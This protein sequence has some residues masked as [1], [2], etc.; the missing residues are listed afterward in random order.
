[1]TF[2]EALFENP[3]L[4]NACVAALLASIASGIVGSY[5]VVKRIAFISGGISHSVLGGIGLFLFLERVFLFS[6]ATPLA[7]AFVS[8]IISAIIIGLI[9]I[10]RK[11]RED[12]VIAALWSIGMALG[13]IF[14][15]MTPGFNVELNNFLVG[16]ILWVTDSDL[17]ILALLDA[18]ILITVFFLHQRFL[19]VCFDEDQA[20]LQEQNVPILYLTL[21]VLTGITVVLLIEVVGIILVMTMLTIPAAIAGSF[22]KRLSHMM[23]LATLFSALFS[24]A[25]IL[26]A[27]EWDFPVGATIALVAGLSYVLSLIFSKRPLMKKA[28]I[29]PA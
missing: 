29:K 27:F 7:G 15:A 5:V 17:Y 9:H 8:A 20:Y 21:L 2:L 24:A 28:G 14:I 18:V 10:Y 25:G 11:E 16:N 26:I 4:F 12:S 1:M 3:L 6:W 13:V 22:T 19:A 23:I